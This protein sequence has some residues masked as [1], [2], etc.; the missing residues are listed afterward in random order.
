MKTELVHKVIWVS[1]CLFDIRVEGGCW[2]IK[3]YK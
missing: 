1:L 3:R 2:F